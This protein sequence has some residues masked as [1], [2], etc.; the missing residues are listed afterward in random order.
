MVLEEPHLAQAVC[1]L[2]EP[3]LEHREG[4]LSK[5]VGHWTVE[6]QVYPK[7]YLLIGNSH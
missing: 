6:F 2:N 5:H 7:P 1:F 4:S 3:S